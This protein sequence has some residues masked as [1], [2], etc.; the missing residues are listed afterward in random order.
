VYHSDAWHPGP[1]TLPTVA[2]Q[3]GT[4]E[5]SRDDLGRLLDELAQAPA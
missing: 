4:L 3:D 2:F 1:G 5:A